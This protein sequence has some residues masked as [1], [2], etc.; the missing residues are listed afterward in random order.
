V[1]A[2]PATALVALAAFEACAAACL[3]FAPV[4]LGGIGPLA[5]ACAALLAVTFAPL[6]LGHDL[7]RKNLPTAAL[8]WPLGG[9]AGYAAAFAAGGSTYAG[10]FSRGSSAAA[11]A[12][13]AS[14]VTA[15]AGF[16]VHRSGAPATAPQ[17]APRPLA[18]I[19]RE[20]LAELNAAGLSP[21]TATIA[22]TPG[23]LI[24]AQVGLAGA[25]VNGFIFQF[26]LGEAVP[27][28]NEAANVAAALVIALAYLRAYYYTIAWFSH[29]ATQG[30]RAAV[31]ALFALTIAA[32]GA[33]AAVQLGILEPLS[34]ARRHQPPGGVW[35]SVILAFAAVP[36][37]V[38]A[39]VLFCVARLDVAR[40]ARR[41][42]RLGDD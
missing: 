23:W 16:A 10:S 32:L 40:L 22:A 18:A 27:Q 36:A 13:A 3:G 21:R 11:A 33:G 9:F 6:L 17:A 31:A 35:D 28:A 41:G 24:A 26:S 12:L 20:T 34:A 38:D 37:G 30:S 4:T 25:L 14:A 39:Y 2:A 8:L 29:R 5:A 1:R 15:L 7:A 19:D 42:Y